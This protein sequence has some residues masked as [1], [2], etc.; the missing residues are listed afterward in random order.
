MGALSTSSP[1]GV[2]IPGGAIALL[3]VPGVPWTPAAG[4]TPPP[5]P[6]SIPAGSFAPGAIVNADVN[7][8][9]GI[10][11]GKLN[12]AASIVNADIA[13][14]AAITKAKLAAL[15][16]VDADV[17]GPITGAKLS[18]IV[19]SAGTR[20]LIA[21]TVTA[22][23]AISGAGGTGDWTCIRNSAGNYTVNF[24]TPLSAVP[25]GVAILMGS[26]VPGLVVV[27][28][29]LAVGSITYQVSTT[30]GVATDDQ[31]TFMVSGPA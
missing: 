27:L 14:G 5:S 23:G 28:S 10:A 7:A 18:G 20:R 25:D 24:T 1:L 15:G 9:A 2:S 26:A 17:T 22:A 13:A 16:I 30:V 8:A 21:G 6:G 4:G 12:L 29:G 11:Y 3:P 19:R 31:T